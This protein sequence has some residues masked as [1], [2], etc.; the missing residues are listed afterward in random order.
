MAERA[1]ATPVPRTFPTARSPVSC[2]GTT[3]SRFNQRDRHADARL[4]YH[5]PAWC[6]GRVE[7][8]PRP[9]GRGRAWRRWRRGR[10]CRRLQCPLRRGRAR[11]AAR[12]PPRRGENKSDDP[13]STDSL[14]I[15]ILNPAG[16]VVTFSL[17]NGI[18][19]P[20]G[21][22]IVFY[23]LADDTGAAGTEDIVVRI[24]DAQGNVVGGFDIDESGFWNLGDRKSTRLNS[25]H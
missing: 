19:V 6:D 11:R 21:G 25:S 4:A 23:Q 24:F 22:F 5:Q 16:Q 2:P 18:T 12:V 7:Q 13:L 3:S 14:T 15:E 8:Q 17:P 1:A 10:R 9:P 20:A